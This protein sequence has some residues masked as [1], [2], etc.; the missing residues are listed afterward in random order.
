MLYSV[1][2]GLLPGFHVWGH[3]LSLSSVWKLPSETRASR[4][5]GDHCSPGPTVATPLPPQGNAPAPV[6]TV[7]EPMAW[8]VTPGGNLS[9]SFGEWLFHLWFSPQSTDFFCLSF[10]IYKTG[11]WAAAILPHSSC[12][13]LG[14]NTETHTVGSCSELCV[15]L[16]VLQN[17][18]LGRYSY[19]HFTDG[20]TLTWRDLVTWWEIETEQPLTFGS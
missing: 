20:E 5:H 13:I 11:V 17:H 18:P 15:I 2:L 12:D 7:P 6:W 8:A 14:G 3:S 9:C 16:F 10:L 1:L 4:P 19:P